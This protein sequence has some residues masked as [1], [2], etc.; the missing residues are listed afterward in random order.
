MAIQKSCGNNVEKFGFLG[1][2]MLKIFVLLFSLLTVDAYA[3]SRA[4]Q[5]SVGA[6]GGIAFKAPWSDTTFRTTAGWGPKAG[7]YG[8]YHTED[9][10]SGLE[11][12]LDYFTLTRQK[13]I[14]RSLMLT[15]FW[16]FLPDNRLHPVIGIGAGITKPRNFYQSNTMD[17]PIF[18]VRAGIEWEWKKNI[19]LVF[20]LDHL[21]IFKNRATEPNAHV[22]IPTVGFSYYFGEP[23]AVASQK[24]VDAYVADQKPDA[25][26]DSDGDGV[27]DS[28][29]MCKT[30]EKGV[31]VNDLGCAEKQTFEIKLDVKFSS[32]TAE[33]ASG[34]DKEL[35]N[36]ASLLKANDEVKVELQGHT[37]SSGSDK[38]NLALSQ[39]RADA[40]RSALISKHGIDADRLVA[41]GYGESQPVDTNNNAGGR[42]NNR[43]VTAVVLN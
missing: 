37:D 11:L 30:T 36:L 17:Q 31:S 38:K 42:K 5:F 22:L 18:R 24:T 10:S 21:S 33:L 34:S 25:P 20:H 2:T 16:R 6:N 12:G 14:S 26:K 28:K 9:G 4:G 1:G 39:A 19:D 3:T 27:P 40:V 13:M 35:A 29:D 23:G 8:R 15:Y 41:K 32:G 7:I 43:R